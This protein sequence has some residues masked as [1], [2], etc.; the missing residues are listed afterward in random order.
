MSPR[1]DNEDSDETVTG[2]PGSSSSTSGEHVRE[3]KRRLSPNSEDD[4]E[5]NEDLNGNDLVKGTRRSPK[6]TREN[7]C[8]VAGKFKVKISRARNYKDVSCPKEKPQR[9]SALFVP[10]LINGALYRTISPS[11]P[12]MLCSFDC[13]VIKYD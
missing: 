4:N 6:Q 12:D 9:L 7:R 8:N 1:K 5:M 2:S 10:C 13:Q 11:I 3:R